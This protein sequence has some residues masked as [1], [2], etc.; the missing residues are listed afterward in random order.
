MGLTFI[1]PECL[2]PPD[3]GDEIT[4]HAFVE[5]CFVDAWLR[6]IGET[7]WKIIVEPAREFAFDAGGIVSMKEPEIRK[8][9]QD[10]SVSLLL[11]HADVLLEQL[12]K[13]QTHLADLG[14]HV[15]V[16]G[17]WTKAIFQ[18]ETAGNIAEWLTKELEGG[19]G[20]AD[21]LWADHCETMRGI[22]VHVPKRRLV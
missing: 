22:G 8:E 5:D 7:P 16:H 19:V 2:V 4:V 10:F 13:T 11:R 21:Q 1:R 12:A 15:W 9:F 6:K 20:Q 17:Y 18:V 3:G 14:P